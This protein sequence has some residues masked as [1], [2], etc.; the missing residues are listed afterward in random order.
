[1]IELRE[2]QF[3]PEN[4]QAYADFYE[5]H[6]GMNWHC[7]D[8]NYPR[9]AF[10]QQNIG[11]GGRALE[12]GCGEGAY[13][14]ALAKA[15]YNVEATDIAGGAIAAFAQ[16]LASE[17]YEIAKWITLR[18]FR[19][20]ELL[21]DNWYDLVVA[22]EVIE[23]FPDVHLVTSRIVDSLCEGGVLLVTTPNNDEF[24]N[25]PTHV[26]RWTKDSLEKFLRFYFSSATVEADA[27]FLYGRAVK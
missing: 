23:H 4:P 24:D 13:S 20:E 7:L 11:T 18:R 8:P 17:P 26:R 25:N 14:Y 10:L 1:M 3:N 27:Q 16:R 6:V 12:I 9:M 2:P 22:F 21:E 5:H 19:A 15:G